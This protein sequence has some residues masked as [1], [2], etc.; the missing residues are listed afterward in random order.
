MLAV[1]AVIPVDRYCAVFLRCCCYR[2]GKSCT[3]HVI[4]GIISRFINGAEIADY[5]RIALGHKFVV[6]GLELGIQV[7]LLTPG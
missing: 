6:H 5:D 2:S 4:A 7:I 3:V 1:I